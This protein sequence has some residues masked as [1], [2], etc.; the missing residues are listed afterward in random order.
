[1]IFGAGKA[2]STTF[3]VFVKPLLI[4]FPILE[5]IS[6][7][8]F[9]CIHCTSCCAHWTGRFAV[10]GFAEDGFTALGTD[11][12]GVGATVPLPGFTVGFAAGLTEGTTADDGVDG[13]TPGFV[14]PAPVL[15]ATATGPSAM[16]GITPGATDS[17]NGD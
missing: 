1:M 17:D 2:S 4:A 5:A 15:G 9:P 16:P 6:G 13:V 8:D 7:I 12:A 14:T 10:R 11:A 3:A